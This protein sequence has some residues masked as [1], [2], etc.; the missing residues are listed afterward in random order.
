MQCRSTI[1]YLRL[2]NYYNFQVIFAYKKHFFL[3][4]RGRLVPFVQICHLIEIAEF[5][6]HLLIGPL[7]MNDEFLAFQTERAKVFVEI[8]EDM[9]N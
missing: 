3:R 9:I 2:L 4:V 5:Q 6:A 8:G 7:S 1:L